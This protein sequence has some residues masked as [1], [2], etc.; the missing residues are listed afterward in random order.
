MPVVRH[1]YCILM[2]SIEA[3]SSADAAFRVEQGPRVR[4]WV[5]RGM[6]SAVPLPCRRRV[7]VVHP[8][9]PRRRCRLLFASARARR[10]TGH[11]LNWATRCAGLRA[12]AAVD[13]TG[14]V[15][16]RRPSQQPDK[17]ERRRLPRMKAGGPRRISHEMCN[18]DACAADGARVGGVCLGDGANSFGPWWPDRSVSLQVQSD[19]ALRAARHRRWDVQLGMHAAARE[20]A[21]RQDL[22]H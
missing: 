15:H 3:L 6:R 8:C 13:P 21:P 17:M 16:H 14:H 19:S 20:L 2:G 1:R 4:G 5:V 22:F 12:I 11:Q 7:G 9:G 18:V 10:Q